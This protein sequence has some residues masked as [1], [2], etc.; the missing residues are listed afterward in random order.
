MRV[1]VERNTAAVGKIFLMEYHRS[2]SVVIVQRAF[3]AKYA[4][5]P[6]VDKTIYEWYKQFTETGCL[7]KQKSSGHPLTA[8]DD[9]ERVRVIR[10][11][12]IEHLWLSKKCFFSFPMT[13]N[14]SIKV[15][16]LVFLL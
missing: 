3:R 11:S 15:G 10:G 5:D 4:N 2:K 9:V 7:C 8:E 12:Q 16:P 1:Y 6:P 13:V 14:N